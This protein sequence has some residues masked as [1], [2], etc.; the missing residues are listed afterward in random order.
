M[1]PT[2]GMDEIRI[3]AP[4]PGTCPICATKHDKHEPH[5]K[6]SL[7]YQNWFYK[8][9][10]RFPTWEDAMDHC[11]EKVKAKCRKKLNRRGITLK[12]A[13]GGQ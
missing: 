10:G 4:T 1:R 9:H 6:G 3:T 7:Y 12:E 8:K 11:D 13:N 5:D 2:E